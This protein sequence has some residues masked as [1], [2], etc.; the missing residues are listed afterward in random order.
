MK[1]RLRCTVYPGQ[2]PSEL[3]VI[4]QSFEGREYSLFAQKRDVITDEVPSDDHP[5]YGWVN[6]QIVSEERALYLVQ[7]PCTTL[8]SGRFLTV[9]GGQLERTPV[10]AEATT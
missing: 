1:T 5:V 10:L 6:V 9:Q 8:E 4:V 3:A 2:F 7:L